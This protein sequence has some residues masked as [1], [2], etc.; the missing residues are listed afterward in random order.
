M[1]S[2]TRCITVGAAAGLRA[3][4]AVSAVAAQQEQPRDTSLETG[5]V[6]GTDTGSTPS[7]TTDTSRAGMSSDTNQSVLSSDTSGVGVTSDTGMTADTGQTATSSDTALKA[8]PGLQTGRARSDTGGVGTTDTATAPT[9]KIRKRGAKGYHHNGAVTDTAL[10]AKPGTQT[11]K[12]AADSGAMK[13]GGWSDSTKTH[14]D[15]LR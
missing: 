15:S 3:L 11:G 1:R 8:K 9:K 6:T 4:G 14:P 12:T 10:H 5:A 7:A 13:S 2:F